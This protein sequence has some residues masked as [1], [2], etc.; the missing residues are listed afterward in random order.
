MSASLAT[1]VKSSE[2]GDGSG[3]DDGGG[4]D[5]GGDD[6]DGGEVD[7]DV[8]VSD[9][10]GDSGATVRFVKASASTLCKRTSA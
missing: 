8:V 6:D 1:W 5:G 4:D 9:G 2:I 7:K 3:G 10:D